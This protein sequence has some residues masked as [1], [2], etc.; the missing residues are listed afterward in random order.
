MVTNGV[1]MFNGKDDTDRI[2]LSF[3]WNRFYGQLDDFIRSTSNGFVQDMSSNFPLWNKTE[4]Y[5]TKY[6]DYDALAR[7]YEFLLKDGSL[8]VRHIWIEHQNYIFS[9]QIMSTEKKDIG[10]DGLKYIEERFRM[11]ND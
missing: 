3:L 6:G 9:T 10:C 7:D 4:L 2:T 11:P 8:Y 1:R 5:K